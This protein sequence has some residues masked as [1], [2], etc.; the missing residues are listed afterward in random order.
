ME[1]GRLVLS[2]KRVSVTEAK[3]SRSEAKLSV[4]GS[5]YA[6]HS[7]SVRGVQQLGS[8][9]TKRGT[10]GTKQLVASAAGE[11]YGGSV[12]MA[13]AFVA[14]TATPTLVA[15]GQ[16]PGVRIPLRVAYTLPGCVFVSACDA[17]KEKTQKRAGVCAPGQSEW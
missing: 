10:P 7:L 11:L 14:A 6:R 13:A 9:G 17:R 16:V 8:S 2:G 15:N 5:K 1:A 4:Y 12:S 3:P